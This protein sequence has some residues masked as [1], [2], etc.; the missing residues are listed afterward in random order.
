MTELT[1]ILLGA[2]LASYGWYW[3]G[4]TDGRTTAVATGIPAAILGGLTVFS[5]AGN[6]PSVAGWALT[7]LAGV[8]GMLVA[9]SALWEVQVDRTLG[10]YSLFFGIA[11]AL[12]AGAFVSEAGVFTLAALAAV[13]LVV[14]LAFMFIAGALIP[15]VRGFR[16]FVGW[17][18]LVGGAVVALI[19]LAPTLGVTA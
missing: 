10:L 3:G 1:F 2:I 14:V 8:F 19:G 17:L 13:V 9:L 4:V 5:V 15:E 16:S 7:A 18:T 12:I 6:T 11:A